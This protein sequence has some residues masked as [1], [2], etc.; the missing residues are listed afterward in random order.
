MLQKITLTQKAKQALNC[1]LGD[2]NCTIYIYYNNGK[3][4]IDISVDGKTIEQG[5]ICQ[6]EGIYPA[7]TKSNFKGYLYFIDEKGASDPKYTE[8]ETRYKLYYVESSEDIQ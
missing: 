5:T 1:V 4:Y 7:Y 3:T 2:Q 8:F 6:Y